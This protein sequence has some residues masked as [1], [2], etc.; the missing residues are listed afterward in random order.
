MLYIYF[1]SQTVKPQLISWR[2]FCVKKYLAMVSYPPPLHY[3]PYHFAFSLVKKKSA[4]GGG[5]GW[6][7]WNGKDD[8]GD[9]YSSTKILY[10]ILLTEHFKEK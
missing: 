5:G 6:W 7:W 10:V 3:Y 2:W 9:I 4:G 8:D 1:I